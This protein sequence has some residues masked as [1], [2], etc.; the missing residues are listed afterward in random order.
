[1]GFAP[2]PFYGVCTLACC[3]PDIR[4]AAAEG[5]YIVGF[6]SK[7]GGNRG[8]LVY[9]MV[10]DEIIPFDDY[11]TDLRFHK[12]RPQF[13][14]SLTLTFGDNIYHRCPVTGGWVQEQSFHS[15]PNSLIGLGNIKRDTHRTDNVLIGR[16]YVYWGGNGPV[17]PVR[18]KPLMRDGARYARAIDDRDL[19]DQFIEW[20][21]SFQE[22]GFRSEPA[23]W[24][25][26]K[27]IRAFSEPE[28]AKC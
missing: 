4:K 20:L 24:S 17:V 3:K 7:H 12:K 6:G 5:D 15:D 19:A 28:A 9:W 2:N 22:R 1:M 18:F 11:W 23:M 26:D 14:K 21:N 8:Q 27:R 10:V 13:G 16:K 25:M